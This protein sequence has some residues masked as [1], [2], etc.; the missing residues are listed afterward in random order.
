MDSTKKSLFTLELVSR[1]WQ[2]VALSIF[3][4]LFSVSMAQAVTM[5]NDVTGFWEPAEGFANRGNLIV[6]NI[7]ESWT[8]VG[9]EA[10]TQVEL[11]TF[12]RRVGLFARKLKIAQT[13]ENLSII[14]DDRSRFNS[15]ISEASLTGSYATLVN[16]YPSIVQRGRNCILKSTYARVPG[17]PYLCQALEIKSTHSGQTLVVKNI[18]KATQAT[19]LL[20]NEW[21]EPPSIITEEDRAEEHSPLKGI[22]SIGRTLFS[23]GSFAATFL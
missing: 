6:S 5:E 19:D 2:R 14:S 16:G 20:P 23:L 4:I 3:L 22:Q 7:S 21:Q 18:L 17:K 10:V 8:G 1:S 15:V 12:L 13:D 9:N 11:S